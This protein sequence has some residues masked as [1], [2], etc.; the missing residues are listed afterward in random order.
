[1]TTSIDTST[2]DHAVWGRLVD[3]A[4]ALQLADRVT[5]FTGLIPGTAG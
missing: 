2:L 1:M 5:L 4:N 3:E